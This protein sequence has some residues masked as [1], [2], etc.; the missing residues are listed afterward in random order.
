M[1]KLSVR[2]HLGILLVLA[3]GVMLFPLAKTDA[4]RPQSLKD[5]LSDSRPSVVSN[6]TITHDQDASGQF[7]SGDTLV[8]TFPAGFTMGSVN[9]T[10]VDF[11]VGSTEET[12]QSGACGSTD[13][14]RAVVSG[15]TLT[16]TAC[17]SYTPEAAGSVIEIEVGTNATA[18][19]A[20]DA[21]ITNNSAGTYTLISDTTDEDAQDTV[22]VIL[23]GVIVSATI[24][25][26]LSVTAAGVSAANCDVTG[27]TDIDTPT[28][29]ATAIPFG[30]LTTEAFYNACQSLTIGT[31]AAG[32][33]QTTLETVDGFKSGANTIAQGVCDAS[34]SI[35]TPAAWGTQTNNGYGYCMKDETG[36]AAATVDSGSDWTAGANQCGGST[37]KFKLVPNRASAQAPEPIMQSSTTEAGDVAEIGW[38]ISAPGDQAAGAYTATGVYTTTGTF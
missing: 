32:G 37:P 8:I 5:V 19:T 24:D 31:N 23:A 35:T 30:T 10:D 4:V 26:S 12:I 7:T 25:E 9:D 14:V 36:N 38:R 2:K 27:G 28:V 20:G 34:C 6:H 15:Q 21:Q 1:G 18:G 13:T 11:K 17:N 29:T 33:Y 22:L 16:F 3:L